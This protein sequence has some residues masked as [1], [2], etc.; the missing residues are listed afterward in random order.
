VLPTIDEAAQPPGVGDDRHGIGAGP[1]VIRL[2]AAPH[3]RFDAENVEVMAGHGLEESDLGHGLMTHGSGVERLRRGEVGE[4]VLRLGVVEE[5][6]V[7]DVGVR[8]LVLD[9][10]HPQ[11]TTGL[12]SRERLVEPVDVREHGHRR[13]ETERQDDHRHDGVERPAAETADGRTKI[14]QD[15]G[16]IGCAPL[17]WGLTAPRLRAT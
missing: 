16:H 2:D 6:E 13:R 9:A 15:V 14:V 10:E 17:R 12:H 11:Q 7:R 3:G 4:R 1:V 8:V 5:I